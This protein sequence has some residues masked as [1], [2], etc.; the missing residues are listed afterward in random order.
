[1]NLKSLLYLAQ[2]EDYD[3]KRIRLWLKNNPDKT[4]TEIKGHLVWTLKTQIIYT[5]ASFLSLF[6]P[7]DQSIILAIKLLQPFDNFLKNLIIFL[8]YTKYHIL[9]TNCICIGITGSWGKTTTKDRLY[10]LLKDN[11]KTV[12]TT[13]NHNTL[14]SIAKQVLT[15]SSDTQVFI[16]EMGA[17][18]RG[19]IKAI[20]QLVSPNIGI[21]TAIGPMHLERFG[22]LQNIYHGKFEL[23]ES[24]PASGLAILPRSTKTKSINYKITAKKK[25]FI[26]PPTI[27]KLIAKHYGLSLSEATTAIKNATI[28]THR[29]ELFQNNGLT[30]IDDSY[31]SNPVGFKKALLKLKKIKTNNRILITPGMIE[32]GELQYQENLKIAQFA[33]TI[34]HHLIVVG[35]TNRLAFSDALKNTHIKVHF[36]DTLKDAQDLLPVIATPG[37]AL[38]FE[39][40]LPDN[41]F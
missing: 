29:Q 24:L 19:D 25:F 32:L 3:P 9:N 31:N 30:I 14:L 11:F 4:V 12:A 35:L 17:Y 27:I 38:L 26:N 36:V 10:Y 41:Y 6:L 40:D 37:S 2:L 22:S 33:Q 5:K 39:N 34:C 15:M 7:A 18:Q 1:M 21:I 28:T 23:A 8:A 16:C 20:C 13:G